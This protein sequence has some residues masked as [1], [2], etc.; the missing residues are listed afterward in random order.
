[1]VVG[2]L[3]TKELSA[4]EDQLGFEGVLCCKYQAAAQNAKEVEL[5]TLYEGYAVQHKQNYDTL[6]NFLK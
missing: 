2:N 1:M 4:L 5:K 6:L 3:T